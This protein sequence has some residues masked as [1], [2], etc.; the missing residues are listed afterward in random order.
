MLIRTR[1]AAGLGT[2]VAATALLVSGA[3]PVQ[4]AGSGPVRTAAA[5]AAMHRHLEARLHGSS[6]HPSVRGHADY[7]S[8]WRRHLDVSVWNARRLAG[9]TLVVYV[10]G[11]KAGTMHIGRGGAGHL[12]RS[13]GVPRCSAGTII[14]IRTRSGG[15]VA[16]GTFRR[17]HH[18]M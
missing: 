6:A 10:H 2:A 16:S 11:T 9:R 15:L 18:M 4:A 13:R 3:V 5:A 17:H 8:S 1:L 12:S 14:R 7:E